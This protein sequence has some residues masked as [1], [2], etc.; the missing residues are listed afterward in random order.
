[1]GDFERA[2][3]FVIGVE[4]GYSADPRDPGN[5]TSGKIGTGVCR[6][7]RFGISAAAYPDLD[8][9]ALTLAE[10]KDI[11]L[12]DYWKKLRCHLIAY[13]GALCLFDAG[14]NHGC[15]RAAVFAQRVTG[16]TQDGI[17]GPHT[18]RAI[19]CISTTEFAMGHL[20][21]RNRF[22]RSLPTFDVYGAG[23]L[24]RLDHLATELSLTAYTRDPQPTKSTK[25]SSHA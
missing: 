6:G 21:A 12:D 16:M 17:V 7:T 13:P 8:I 11:Y 18:L 22:Y 2:F 5:W 15:H 9:A 23:W 14:V 10:A 1:M 3:T 20:T 19:N 25:R 4:G 24:N